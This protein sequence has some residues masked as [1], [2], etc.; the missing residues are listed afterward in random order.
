[1]IICNN[2]VKCFGEQVVLNNISCEFAEH[3]FYLLLGE[4]GSGKTTFLNILAGFLPFEAGH[5]V[6]GKQIFA[7]TVQHD[8]V[9]SSFDYITQDSFFVDFLSVADNLRLIAEDDTRICSILEQLGLSDKFN[10]MPLTLSGGEKQRLAI[11]R[12]MLGGKRILFLDEPTAA[13]DEENKTAVFSLLAK[14][15]QDFLII[16]SSHDIVAKEYADQ[17]IWFP[18]IKDKCTCVKTPPPVSVAK[19]IKP[20]R[21]CQKKNPNRYLKK[22]F[23]SNRRHRKTNILFLLFLILSI[24]LCIFADTPQNKFDTSIEYMY[25]INLLTVSIHDLKWSDIAPEN[26]SVQ[27]VVIHYGRSC[28]M[29]NGEMSSNELLRP[30]PE[31][32]VSLNVLPFNSENFKLSDNI[33]YGSYFTKPNQVIL[34]W[35]MANSIA[36]SD[37][38]R[39]IGEQ[40]SKNIYGLGTVRLEIV[41]IFNQFSKAEKVYLN[42]IDISIADGEAYSSSNY[43]NLYFV[44]SALINSLEAN[45]S[46]YT[47]SGQR[48]YHIYFDSFKDMKTYYDQYYDELTAYEGVIVEY[49]NVN[50]EL[51]FV[52]QALFY[53][54]LPIA[55]FMAFFTVL[56]YIAL[57]KTELEYN[58]QFIAVFEYSG[59]P[60]SLV[61]KRFI[62]LNFCSLLGMLV[63]AQVIAFVIAFVI[64]LINNRFLLVGFQIFSY[65]VPM[66][67]AF[68]LF[69]L[70]V[71]LMAVNILFRQVKVLS[72]YDNLIAARDLV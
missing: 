52:F 64:N 14:I 47:D 50:I 12:A 60:K 72:W 66:I 22:W 18:K 67:I 61:I 45:D 68:D 11:A 8:L 28:P 42:A 41:G 7:N 48:V 46:F 71:S 36:P 55:I 63:F 58:H 6:W 3:G 9:E 38:K 29:G 70:T 54:L 24:C 23:V 27:E 2:L 17:V 21:S 10:Q 51:Q 34:S 1:M 20:V 30:N 4:S 56:F 35:E 25:K 62:G 19:R 15:S 13:L 44:N 37:P 43:V 49:S 40:I 32:E 26:P 31:Y 65:N 69:V 16:C 33:L 57:K 59:Y 39:L 5:I 53:T